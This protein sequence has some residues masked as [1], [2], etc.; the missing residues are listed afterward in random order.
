V[1]L[2]FLDDVFLLD[3][4]L[5]PA[6]RIFQR[7]AFLYTNFCQRDPT[8]KPANWLFLEY[9]KEPAMSQIKTLSPA[10]SSLN[11]K[12]LSLNRLRTCP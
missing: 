12:N 2:D 4:P 11:R 7:L 8:S 3:L 6:Q 10:K 9:R 5:E 1:T